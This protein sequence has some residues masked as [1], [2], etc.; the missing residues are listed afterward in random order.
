VTIPFRTGRRGVLLGVASLPFLA[1]RALASELFVVSSGAM[2]EAFRALG[3]R[4]TQASGIAIRAEGGS[5]MGASPTAIPQR[6][7]RGEP[8]DVMLMAAEALDDMMAKGLAAAGTRVDIARSLIG[9]AVRDGAPMPDIATVEALRAVLLGAGSIGYSASASGVYIETEM[10]RRLGIHDE[11]MP[12]SRKILT[13]RVAALVARGEVEIGF[14]QVSEILGV[15][16]ARFVGTIPE[17]VQRPTIFAGGLGAR[18]Q[19]AAA[20]RRLLAFLASRDAAE[21]LRQTGLEPLA[22]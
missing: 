16:G 12:K 11:V 14:Q 7:A 22:G 18:M 5:S 19:H 13:E 6:L 20:G 15:P 4:F 1:R 2:F 17:A 9:M 3:P 8:I 10:Y 21:V